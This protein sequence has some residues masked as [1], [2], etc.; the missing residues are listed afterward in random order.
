MAFNYLGTLATDRDKV[1][2]HLRDTVEGSGVFPGDANLTDA[3]IDGLVSAAGSWQRAVGAGFRLLAAA[4]DRHPSFQADGLK[5]NRSDIAK[6]FRA[7]AE[8]W[9]KSYGITSPVYVAGIIRKDGYSDD[10]ASDDVTAAGEYEEEWEYVTP[11][12]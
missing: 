3:E 5:L 9:E 2:F 6:G 8:H 11:R 1:R 12:V 10:I 4:W 7:E